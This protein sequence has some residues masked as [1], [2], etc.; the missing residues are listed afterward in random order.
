MAPNTQSG[1]NVDLAQILLTNQLMMQQQAAF[2]KTVQ[3]SLMAN[4][5]TQNYEES[6]PDDEEMS[7]SR[8][9]DV[10]GSDDEREEHNTS[11]AMDMLDTDETNQDDKQ[12]DGDDLINLTEFMNNTEKFGDKID[13]ALA[14]VVNEHFHD[15]VPK[16]KINDLTTKYLT[17]ANCQNLVVPRMNSGIWKALKS[18]PKVKDADAKLQR[19]QNFLLKAFFPLLN[20]MSRL[21]K[22]KAGMINQSEINEMKQLSNDTLKL[23]NIAFCDISYRRRY[24][25][26][27]HLQKE[28]ADLCADTTKITKLLFGDDLSK[29]I[30]ETEATNKIAKT[31]GKS[32]PNFN[33]K[34]D[35][36]APKTQLSPPTNSNYQH[37]Y[38]RNFA[39]MAR[40]SATAPPPIRH[41]QGRNQHQQD[42]NRN[43]GRF[44]GKSPHFKNKQT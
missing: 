23:M 3:E 9:S 22:A 32:K 12:E 36:K 13:D 34:S 17:P 18:C 19:S 4:K 5:S 14:A 44:L 28:F 20:L 7:T 8:S 10:V 2:M 33:K 31:V 15:R 40:A 37:P 29:T 39:H 38:N 26:Q 6:V 43:K 25:I 42:D 35:L 21:R 1:S 24:L 16:E 11:Y 27:P 41:G 30:T